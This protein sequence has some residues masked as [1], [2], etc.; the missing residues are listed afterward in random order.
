MKRMLSTSLNQVRTGGRPV[1]IALPGQTTAAI[2]RAMRKLAYVSILVF[3]LGACGGGGGTNDDE[4]DP[5]ASTAPDAGPG[6]W[7]RLIG[8]S[9]TIPAGVND[10]YR[11]TRVRVEQ[12]TYVQGFRS[13]APTGSHHAVLT[14]ADSNPGQLGDYNCAVGSLDLKMLYASGVGTDDLLFPDDVGV[15]IP[16][17]SYLNLNLHLFNAGENEISGESA[18]LVKALP[19]APGTLAGMTFAGD[20]NLSIPSNGEPHDEFGGCTLNSSASVI[21]LW[22]HMHQYAVHQKVELTRGGEVTML[23]DDEYSFSDQK[24]Y[25]QNPILEL[26]AGDR[27]DVTCTYVNNTGATINWGDSSTAEMCF[28]GFYQYPAPPILFGCVNQ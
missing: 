26:Q 4:P 25:P 7:T 27:I 9:W 10:I 21:A 6:D 24:N 19:A 1:T 3:G 11:C 5:D 12:D 20:Q 13:V 14:V 16:A 2:L 22:P 18:V 8:R 15:L 17:G 28:T 23:L